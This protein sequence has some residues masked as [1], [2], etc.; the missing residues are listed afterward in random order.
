MQKNGNRCG[1]FLSF[2]FLLL[3]FS[4]QHY[5]QQIK[6]ILEVKVSS[7][8]EGEAVTLS[9][10]LSPGV[11]VNSARVYFRRFGESEF[12]STEMVLTGRWAIATLP[13]RHISPPYFEYY[14]ELQTQQASVFYPEESPKDNPVKVAVEGIDPKDSEVRILSPEQGETVVIEDFVVAV[15]LL[16]ASDVVAKQKT[17]VYLDGID[18]TSETVLS[19]DVILYNPAPFGRVL[20]VG[21]HSLAI[22]LYDTLGRLYY[23]KVTSFNLLTSSTLKEQER[24]LHTNGSSQLEFRNEKIENTSTTYLRGDL[25]LGAVYRSFS[26]ALDVHLTNE[27]KNTIQPQNRFLGT[28]QWNDY[29]KLQVGDAYPVFPSL[30]VSG[31]RVRGVSGSLTLGFFNL[32]VSY[33]QTER[34][35]EG[36]VIKD[37]SYVD[38]S[39]AS[40]RPKASLPLGGLTYRLFEAGTYKRTMFAMRPS[41]G[42][43]ENF[44]LGFT[45]VKTK[46]DM[47]SIQYGIYPKENIVGGADFTLALADQ[48]IKWVT[49]VAFSLSNT[50]ISAGN[51]SDAAIDSIKGVY[52]T[53]KTVAERET[54]KKEAEDL[55]R[56]ASLG[57]SFITVNEY[58]TP[59]DPIT[60]L[61]ST[62]I[63]SELT[64]N[65]FNNFIRIVGFRRGKS[66]VSFGNEFIQTDIQGVNISDRIRLLE[67]RV[68]LSVAY[69]IK[70]NNT[71]NEHS[72]PTTRYNTLSTSVTVFPGISFPSITVGYGFYTRKNSVDLSPH[73]QPG[74]PVLPLSYLPID[75]VQATL[76]RSLYSVVPDE[77]VLSV[78]NEKTDRVFVGMNYDFTFIE[79]QSVTVTTTIAKKSD[80]TFYKRNQENTN[81]SL[82][83]TT[84]YRIP[85][86]TTLGIVV[87][88]NSTFF[89][90]RDSVRAY[91]AATTKTPFNYQ[92]LTLNARYR[93]FEN[94]LQLIVTCSPSFGDFRR[95]LVQGGA[96]YE[97]RENHYVTAEISFIQYPGRPNDVLAGLLYRFV[98]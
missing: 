86:Q 37:T 58:L 25:Q 40:S 72:V 94:S 46:D 48:R 44:Q 89:A 76:Y 53:T 35:I 29:L 42:S 41:F 31:K 30:F 9:A 24:V 45:V 50:D 2:V 73:L 75:T 26:G 15:S 20:D 87:S 68:L 74:K 3:C 83:V 80:R 51:L 98:F 6:F 21:A 60:K 38:T 7:A 85:L 49:Q 27:E 5:A 78:A 36:T 19:D 97:V 56:V 92:T 77:K 52:D 84:R 33:G 1:V 67:N 39:A 54:A 47:S 55:K 71:L 13:A 82:S 11:S 17:R 93:L 43:G 62:A 66:F 69:E 79:R 34:R 81:V 91:T 96:E 32:D 90:L 22:H 16:Y 64:I 88:Q 63:E 12:R 95:F 61:P 4:Y 23:T 10:Q 59:L 14:I 70:S 8:R 28:I 57:R 18:V 65:L